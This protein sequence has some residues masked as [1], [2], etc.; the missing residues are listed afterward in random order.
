MPSSSDAVATRARISP[1][2]RRCSIASLR[3]LERLPWWAA[4]AVL[5]EALG[6]VVRDALGHAPCVDEDERRRTLA[7]ERR[8]PVVDL[9]PLLVRWD[10]L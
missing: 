8:E 9:G 5:A 7:D 3:S 10:G 6:R 2:L 4:D 1:A